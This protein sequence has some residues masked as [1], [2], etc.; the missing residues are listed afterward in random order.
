MV[1][2]RLSNDKECYA[3]HINLEVVV[4]VHAM[5]VSITH[6]MKVSVCLR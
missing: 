6:A 1:R 3:L 2:V 4:C 5:R